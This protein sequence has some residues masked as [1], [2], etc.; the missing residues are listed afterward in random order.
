[1]ENCIT[2]EAPT[3]TRPKNKG[4]ISQGKRIKNLKK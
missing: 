3:I 1:M 2:L 4:L